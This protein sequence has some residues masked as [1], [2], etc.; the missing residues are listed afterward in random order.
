M[1]DIRKD[2]VLDREVIFNPITKKRIETL[3]KKEFI[4]VFKI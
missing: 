1:G 2:Y 3:S 4:N